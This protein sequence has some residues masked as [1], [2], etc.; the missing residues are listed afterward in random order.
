MEVP[1]SPKFQDQEVGELV[2]V[3]VKFIELVQVWQAGATVNEAT[4][5]EEVPETVTS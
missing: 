1:P 3:S 5:F 2:E 4:G